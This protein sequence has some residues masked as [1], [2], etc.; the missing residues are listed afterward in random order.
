MCLK[1]LDSPCHVAQAVSTFYTHT[2]THLRCH[3]IVKS[4]L[5]GRTPCK[6]F[7]GCACVTHTHTHTHMKTSPPSHT[8]LVLLTHTLPP[9]HHTHTHAVPSLCCV[10]QTLRQSTSSWSSSP[11]SVDALTHVMHHV[12]CVCVCVCV[13]GYVT[14]PL[15]VVCPHRSN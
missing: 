6:I 15:G 9:H 5:C 7:Y 12:M 3:L 14:Y 4:C 11:V 1:P 10:V 2:H 8:A 13:C